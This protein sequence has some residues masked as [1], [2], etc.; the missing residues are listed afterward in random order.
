MSTWQIRR[1]KYSVTTDFGPNAEWVAEMQWPEGR[2][3]G[4]PAVLLIYPSDPDA[5]PP[6]GLSQT[7]LRDMNFREALDLLRAGLTFSKR[8]QR[9]RQQVTDNLAKL[10]I[11]HAK[12]GSITPAYLATLSRAYL[13]AVD[14]GQGRPLDHL[15]GITGKSTAAIKNH[16]WQATRKGILVRSP[17]RAGGHLTT[18]GRTELAQIMPDGQDPAMATEVPP[19]AP[20]GKPRRRNPRKAI[21]VTG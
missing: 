19:G 18:K 4:G 11:E 9:V 15:A 17:G 7:V 8:A 2:T 21:T 5:C 10:L 20:S 14:N 1:D 13:D 6:G 12:G 3:Q 16:L